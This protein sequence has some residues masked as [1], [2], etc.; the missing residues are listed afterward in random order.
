MLG[1][2][3]FMLVDVKTEAEVVLPAELKTFRG[4]T[5]TVTDIVGP[6]HPASSG[7]VQ[8][9]AGYFY[10]TVVGCVIRERKQP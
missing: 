4:D 1:R 7:H 3:R 8:T 9:S 10:P 5:V 6:S 2:K